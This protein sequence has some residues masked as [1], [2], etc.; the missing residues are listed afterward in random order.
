MT[1]FVS[2]ESFKEVGELCDKAVDAIVANI[3]TGK[4]MKVRW[5]ACYVSTNTVPSLLKFVARK[6][7]N[8]Q[9]LFSLLLGKRRSPK[10]Y[11]R[12]DM[13]TLIQA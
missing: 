6:S 9:I 3:E 8:L 10:D 5:N 4:V 13:L 7:R 1:K 12:H 2:L 11:G